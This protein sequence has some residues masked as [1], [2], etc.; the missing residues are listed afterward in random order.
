[1]LPGEPDS[2]FTPVVI[3]QASPEDV[4]SSARLDFYRQ[5][6]HALRGHV[7]IRDRIE[8]LPLARL[9]GK[10]STDPAEWLDVREA[11]IYAPEIARVQ[12]IC[13]DEAQHLMHA[14][15]MQR[16]G[17]QLDWLKSLTNR[18]NLLYILVGNFSL[19]DKSSFVASPSPG[20]YLGDA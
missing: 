9:R 4:G 15:A 8:N 6:L 10:R 11:V 20:R 16:P 12:A 19:Y 3:V 13:V 1:M 5:V 14:D 17:V 18:T 2:S 7:A